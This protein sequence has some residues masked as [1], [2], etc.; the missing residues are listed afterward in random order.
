MLALS[1]SQVPPPAGTRPVHRRLPRAST[2]G[3]LSILAVLA[4]PAVPAAAGRNAPGDT[5]V[6][7]EVAE[8]LRAG[9]RAW[10]GRA[11]TVAGEWRADPEKVA[12]AVTS[13]RQAVDA[14]PGD[15]TARRQLLA[16]LYFQGEHV[17]MGADERREIFDRGKSAAEEAL[18]QLAELAGADREAFR[19]LE[20]TERAARLRDAGVPADRAAALYF[21]SGVHWGLWGDAYGRFAAARAGVAGTVRDDALT[22]LDLDPAVER[23][24]PHRVLGRLHSEAPKIPFFTGWVDRDRAIAELEKAVEMAPDEPLNHLYLAQALLDH[25][26]DRERDALER[27]RALLDRPTDPE[28]A[29]EEAAARRE[30]RAI[31]QQEA[32]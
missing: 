22:A 27:L 3:V 18:G 16:A 30:A 11:R 28:R 31:I 17:A 32:P 5:P 6:A 21:W 15:L 7:S 23:A 26:P 2:L 24:G 19:E 1:H 9:D 4:L 12:E 25:H 13:Y 14:A 20:P 29:V 10:A 8:L